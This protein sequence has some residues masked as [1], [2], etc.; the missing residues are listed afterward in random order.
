MKNAVIILVLVLAGWF[1]INRMNT[2]PQKPDNTVTQYAD[3]L[4]QSEKSAVEAA[5]AANLAVAR[6][7]LSRFKNSE[8]RIPSSAEEMV[9]LNY[10]DRIPQHVKYDTK[11]GSFE[12]EIK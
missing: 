4:E 8:G 7:A 9:E 11:S 1:V 12:K 6:A 10:L 2:Q 5:A 3:N